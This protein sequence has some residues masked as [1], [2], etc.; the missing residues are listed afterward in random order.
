VIGSEES[1]K[2]GSAAVA[3]EGDAVDEEEGDENCEAFTGDVDPPAKLTARRSGECAAPPPRARD[4]KRHGLSYLCRT[5]GQ[6]RRILNNSDFKYCDSVRLT[7]DGDWVEAQGHFSFAR[8]IRMRRQSGATN[9]DQNFEKDCA[10][11]ERGGGSWR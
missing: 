5:Q 1:H 4:M 8:Q 11:E 2:E 6:N 9:L 10:S 3:A 7:L